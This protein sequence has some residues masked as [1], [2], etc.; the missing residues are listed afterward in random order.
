MT[1]DGITDKVL[2][3]IGRAMGTFSML[4]SGDRVAV[5]V[6]GGKDSMCL[7]HAL[8][9]YR[10]RARFPYELIA[11]TLDQ[12]KFTEPIDS[13]K[14]ALSA[15]GVPWVIR[16]D[17]RTLELVRDRVVHGC[18]V[19]SRNRRGALYRIASELDCNV[20]ALG[21]TADDCAEALFRNVMFNG[22]LGALPPVADSRGGELR[23]VRPLVFVTEESTAR[24]AL[25][26]QLT[27]LGCVCG[28]KVGP[29]SEIRAFLDQMGGLHPGVR[30]SI[31]AALG[32]VN[33]YTL[34]DSKLTKEGADVPAFAVSEPALSS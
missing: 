26:H 24:Y 17:P 16:E 18:D 25:E 29:R 33:P 30:E 5:G 8:H 34:F 9:T 14:E 1:R 32:N 31:T 22:R 28:E 23:I 10:R 13:V 2:R 11:V 21:H 3:D 15:I 19:C 20:L 27:T 12:G 7:V 6:S 4:R